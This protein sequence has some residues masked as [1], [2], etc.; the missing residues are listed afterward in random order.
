MVSFTP[1]TEVSGRPG[2]GLWS[3]TVAPEK[4]LNALDGRDFTFEF[5]LMMMSSPIQDMVLIDLGDKYEPGFMKTGGQ[6]LRHREYLR[7]IQGRMPGGTRPALGQGVAPRRLHLPGGQQHGSVF[8]RRQ[9]SGSCAAVARGK[10]QGTGLDLARFAAPYDLRHFRKGEEDGHAGLRIR[11]LQVQPLP[12]AFLQAVDPFEQK[13]ES[14][15]EMVKSFLRR[16][17][18]PAVCQRGHFLAFAEIAGQV[19]RVGESHY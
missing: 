12:G 7:R 16:S 13:T 9:A 19:I 5:W 3:P 14:L 17:V 18:F 15:C 11:R 1:M 6:R 4:L 2:S 8:H 10:I